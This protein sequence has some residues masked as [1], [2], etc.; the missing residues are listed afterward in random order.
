MKEIRYPT[1]FYNKVTIFGCALFAV[2][3]VTFVTL[4]LLGV[5]G[6]GANPYF[7]IFMHMVLPPF[8]LVGLLLIPWGM[9]RR[10][11]VLRERGVDGVQKWPHLDLNKPAHRRAAGL[12]L[13]ATLLYVALSAVGS[14][15]AYHHTESVA[16]CGLTCHS[17]MKPE[18]TA[19]Q[20][21]SHARVACTACH[22]GEGASWYAKSKL[23]GAYQ[24]YATAFDKY[25]RPIGTP[26]KNLRPAQETCERCHWP[27]RFYGAQQRQFNH[28][29]YD[30][31]NTHWPINMLIK[32]GGGD[33]KTGQTAGIHWHM[34][35]GVQ[36]EYIARDERRQDIPWMRSTDRATGRVT[37]YQDAE[38]PLSEEEIAAATPRVMDC[39]DCHN[40][41]SHKFHSPDYALDMAL[42]TGHVPADLPEVKRAAVEAVAAEYQTESEALEAIAENLRGFYA[43][44]Y[45]E[46][47]ESR[48]TDVERAIAG[49][50][51]VFSA[52][53]FPEMKVR[54]D[55]Y[56]DNIGHFINPGCFRCHDGNKISE[57]GSA[58][59][60]DCRA[61]HTILS[62]GSGE[63]AQMASS[64]E[65]L[66]FVH[67]E[68]IDDE[69]RET[70]CYE[71][72]EGTQP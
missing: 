4:L 25:P 18:Y 45:P 42:L 9:V 53:V 27:E 58:V 39:M 51:R 52:N 37:T 8:A 36:V 41:P 64:A 66:E 48:G 20:L 32:T 60:S 46:V 69:W 63:R 7:G 16:F 38:D 17:V 2:T 3:A 12:F 61:C 34:N 28:Y 30:E 31:A 70:G 5:G 29:M 24:V 19:Y 47:L 14:Y 26:I 11:R 65:G 68:D 71:C 13:A 67:P 22:V 54:W 15:Q 33:P 55:E 72:H 57:D 10:A 59:T 49:T 56:P 21:S 35:I 1:L 50:Q 43:D 23:S 44:E 6:V 40:R 62:Q